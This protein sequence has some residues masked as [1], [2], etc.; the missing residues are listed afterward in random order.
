M[1]TYFMGWTCR[2]TGLQGLH[3]LT[4]YKNS[5]DATLDALKYNRMYPHIAHNV[6]RFTNG[7]DFT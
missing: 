6:Y 5:E 1:V 3:R 2:L 7:E 4:P